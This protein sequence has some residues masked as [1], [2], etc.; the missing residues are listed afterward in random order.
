M[1]DPN[2]PFDQP[3]ETQPQQPSSA[4]SDI[5]GQWNSFLSKPGAGQFMLGMGINLMQPPHFGDTP[6]SQIG[7]AVGEGAE[8][9]GRGE[10]QEAKVGELE[11]RGRAALERS[12]YAGERL[13]L[14]QMV[15]DQINKR[16]EANQETQLYKAY[17]TD[18]NN[19][20]KQHAAAMKQY[21]ADLN[22]PLRDPKL[23][24][25]TAPAPLPPD[26][27]FEDWLRVRAPGIHQ[28][29]NKGRP[30]SQP[31]APQ[32]TAQTDEA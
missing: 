9:V 6:T 16:N 23:P 25:P 22:N 19:A 13:G 7:R 14:Q 12:A 18:L 17:V 20:K 29:M 32:Q 5:A 27:S 15:Q 24:P 3:P 4:F 8:A 28:R 30:A 1:A 21:N 11:A 31:Q 10:F 26:P 2:L